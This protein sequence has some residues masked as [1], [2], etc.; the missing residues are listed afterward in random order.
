[1]LELKKEGDSPNRRKVSEST[2]MTMTILL[3]RRG[4]TES[5]TRSA[6][7]RHYWPLKVLVILAPAIRR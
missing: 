7:E 3:D 5:V 6:R 4:G 1:M 2:L